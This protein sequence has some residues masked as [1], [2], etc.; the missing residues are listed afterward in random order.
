MHETNTHENL[1]KPPTIYQ[2]GTAIVL[3]VSS[4]FKSY[5]IGF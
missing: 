3:W 2:T 5:Q 1:Y 4:V